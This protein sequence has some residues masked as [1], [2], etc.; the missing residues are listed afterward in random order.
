M[1]S[2]HKILLGLVGFGSVGKD[3]VARY[4][5]DKHNFLHISCSDMIRKYMTDHNLG[6]HTRE[7]LHVVGNSLREKYGSDYLIVLSLDHKA[8]RLIISGLR[9]VGEAE[10][11]KKEGG[12]LIGVTAPVEVRYAWGKSRGGTKD[13]VTFEQ[14]KEME[15]KE[16]ASK[17][18]KA[19]S[20]REVMAMA[21][22]TIDNSGSREDL[23]KEIDAV[24]SKVTNK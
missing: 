10:R 17:D 2:E 20:I 5:V 18:P 4:L 1:Q 23:F 8:E 13:H 11:L 19:Q 6:E 16:A 24:V 14:F 22:V 7:N 12:I 3:T 15:E 9:N 21:D